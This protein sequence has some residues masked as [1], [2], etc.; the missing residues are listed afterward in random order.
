MKDFSLQVSKRNAGLDPALYVVETAASSQ[1]LFLPTPSSAV[2]GAM[3]DEV[4]AQ[5]LHSKLF[6]IA[7]F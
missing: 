7:T 1:D 4:E 6:H 5:A 2:S 3:D